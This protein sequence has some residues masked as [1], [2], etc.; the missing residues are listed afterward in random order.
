MYVFFYR[1]K[2][3]DKTLGP[4]VF[5]TRFFFFFKL[6]IMEIFCLFNTFT[7]IFGFKC[8]ILLCSLN[9]PHMFC[10]F[11]SPL[12]S[13]RLKEYFLKSIF[14]WR[15]IALKCC[16]AF[17]LTTRISHNYTCNTSLLSPSPTLILPV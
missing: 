15:K 1:G 7:G 13:L 6:F 12:L 4:R 3:C 2:L 14:N 10:V 8:T 17:C 9:F 11:F 5:L 16:V